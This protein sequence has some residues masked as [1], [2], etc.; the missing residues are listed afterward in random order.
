MLRL[1]DRLIQVNVLLSAESR[2]QR[3]IVQGIFRAGA[4]GFKVS[5]KLFRS[6]ERKVR[7][8]PRYTI[9]PLISRPC[10]KPAIVWLTTA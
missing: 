8:P 1:A 2:S 6:S 7:G 5:S 10:A 3:H 9:F 4:L